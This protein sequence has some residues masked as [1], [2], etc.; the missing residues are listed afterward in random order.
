MEPAPT[1][2][3]APALTV[4]PPVTW[5]REFAGHVVVPIVPLTVVKTGA[6][7]NVTAGF[8]T[9]PLTA[10]PTFTVPAA[11][12]AGTCTE[13]QPRRICTFVEGKPDMATSP[14]SRTVSFAPSTSFTASGIGNPTGHAAGAS[15][16]K[17]LPANADGASC[18]VL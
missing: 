18:T 17:V 3:V 12:A 14:F 11:V 4:S 7:S 15:A 13:P 6:A 10:A 2:S 8:E 9:R 16:L 5:M 1:V